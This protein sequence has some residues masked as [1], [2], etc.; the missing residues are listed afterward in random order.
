[1]GDASHDDLRDGFWWA[2][3]YKREPTHTLDDRD[4]SQLSRRRRVEPTDPMLA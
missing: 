3:R 1:M 2:H 4:P